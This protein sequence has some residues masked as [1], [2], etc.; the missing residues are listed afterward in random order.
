M[1]KIWKLIKGLFKEDEKQKNQIGDGNTFIGSK[2][3]QTNTKIGEIKI[4]KYEVHQGIKEE[5]IEEIIK[6][7][8]IS[9]E[10]KNEL[11]KLREEKRIKN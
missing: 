5:K 4:D 6:K 2:I 9:I 8:S 3:N 7:Y 1:N 10:A 11:S